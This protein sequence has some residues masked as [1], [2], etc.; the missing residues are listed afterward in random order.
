MAF[1]CGKAGMMKSVKDV[2]SGLADPAGG[3]QV[4]NHMVAE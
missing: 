1:V 2:D 3:K 4:S